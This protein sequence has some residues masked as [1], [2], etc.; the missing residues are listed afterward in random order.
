MWMNNLL[1]KIRKRL[2]LGFR[3]QIC[4]YIFECALQWENIFVVIQI[5]SYSD[6][7]LIPSLKNV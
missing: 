2:E 3:V 1:C 4:G 6:S 5:G 7:S